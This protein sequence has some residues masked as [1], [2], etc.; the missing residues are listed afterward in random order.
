MKIAPYAIPLACLVLQGQETRTT[1][2]DRLNLGATFYQNG[3]AVIRDTRR[4]DLPSGR[5]RLAFGDLLPTIRAKSATLVDVAN[6][7]Q[8]LER[9]YIFDLLSPRALLEKSLGSPAWV[10]GKDGSRD[11]T[12]S[13]ASLPLLRPA[14]RRDADPLARIARLPRAFV[15]APDPN[16]VI[17]TQQGFRP[18]SPGEVAFA[19]VPGSLRPS[20]TLLQ[21]VLAPSPGPRNL[22]LIYSATDLKWSAN[23]VANLDP[24]GSHLDLTVFATV[25]NEGDAA[26]P[27]TTLQLVAGLPT[28]VDDDPPPD[29]DAPRLDT[30]TVECVA[31]TA[32]GP[33]A[34]KEEKVSEYPVF[35][36]DRPVS[37][38]ARSKKQLLLLQGRRIPLEQTLLAESPY[39]D[40]AMDSASAFMDS[41]T[42]Q[43]EPGQ[44][45]FSP[46]PI[47]PRGPEDGAAAYGQAWE[48]INEGERQMAQW[49]ARHHPRVQRVGRLINSPKSHLGRALPA[50]D[51]EIRY[52]DPSGF[53]FPIPES[54]GAATTFPMTPSGE[55]LELPLGPAR[56][57]KV[58]R[59]PIE[60][61]AI[62]SNQGKGHGERQ[63]AWT[64]TIEV[65]VSSAL[66]TPSLVTVREPVH[67]QA[68][69]LRS[70]RRGMRSGTNAF[71]FPLKVPA[72]GKALLRYTV[73]TAPEP[74]A[75]DESHD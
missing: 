46:L 26:L 1:A 27:D 53:E 73:R 4:I 22:T 18:A 25:E 39:P 10:M 66:A 61:R 68:T 20:P 21:D 52:R 42:F 62:H 70:S 59:R 34:F 54:V 38:P 5:S 16:V 30:A 43:P 33:P 74:V 67:A 55:T 13:L 37:I 50:G 28:L 65:E 44:V 47:L 14:L 12:G 32:A 7:V 35:T 49:T 72:H 24:D 23:Y 8:I 3:I 15:Q 48:Q 29:P 64:Y 40:Y 45:S 6:E 63:I 9:N 56:G 71:D 69:L 60:K 19:Q 58:D 17:A 75:N 11:A 51:L 31:A 36:L 2:K 41:E 57:F